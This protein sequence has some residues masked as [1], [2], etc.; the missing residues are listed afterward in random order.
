[1]AS[2]PITSWQVEGEKV[3]AV[4]N[5]IFMGYNLPLHQ[6]GQILRDRLLLIYLEM[7]IVG[8]DPLCNSC[9]S[10]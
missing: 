6:L 10:P 5:F 3:E 2:S 4:R 7:V 1:M 8:L 9:L